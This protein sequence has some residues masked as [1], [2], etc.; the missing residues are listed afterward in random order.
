[1]MRLGHAFAFCEEMV[2]E[3]KIKA[4]GV[5]SSKVFLVDPLIESIQNKIPIETIQI[6]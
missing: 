5:Q 1:M 2:Q 6:F 4:Y 3:G